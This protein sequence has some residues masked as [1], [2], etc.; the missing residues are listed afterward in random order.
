[1]SDQQIEVLSQEEAI[2]VEKAEGTQMNYFLYPEFEIHQ[3]ILPAQTIQGWHQHQK[4]EETL[5]MTAGS[6]VVETIVAGEKL[7]QTCVKG[8][9][10]RMKKS[11]HRII[12]PQEITA[13]FIVFR[14]VPQGQNQQEV[15]KTDKVEF[16]QAEVAALLKK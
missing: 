16:S 12:N 7:S 13:E 1:M 15:I 5:V 2:F 14:F 6:I 10:I 8:D 11:L 4:I 3:N 9:V